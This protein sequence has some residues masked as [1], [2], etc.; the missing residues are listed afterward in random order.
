MDGIL[1]SLVLWKSSPESHSLSL[2]LQ[3][4]WREC[5]CNT[6]C[7]GETLSYRYLCITR[8]I[9][10]CVTV[11]MESAHACTPLTSA[12]TAIKMITQRW[13]QRERNFLHKRWSFIVNMGQSCTGTTVST[14]PPSLT[15]NN[16]VNKSVLD[17]RY[18]KPLLVVRNQLPAQL[19]WKWRGGQGTGGKGG[20]KSGGCFF[21]SGTG[22][23][24]IT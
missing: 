20:F 18:T 8:I 7:D 23:L 2:H 1:Q 22:V 4:C 17:W 9:S 5:S 14:H 6:M 15:F 3:T 13:R 12:T 10:A 24:Y 11:N 21:P 19:K 16:S